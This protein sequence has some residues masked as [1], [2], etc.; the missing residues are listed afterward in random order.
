MKKR[1]LLLIVIVCLSY[2]LFANILQDA[3]QGARVINQKIEASGLEWEAG[4]NAG[5]LNPFIESIN[6]IDTFYEGLC[7]H[8]PL[9]EELKRYLPGQP[10]QRMNTT[11]DLFLSSFIL[12]EPET[13]EGKSFYR[14]EPVRNQAPYGS[15]WAFS[16]LAS[17]ESARAVQLLGKTENGNKDNALDYSERWVGYHNY[18][19]VGGTN[20]DQDR[21]NGGS[22][23]FAMYN[24]IRY[25]MIDESAAPYSQIVASMGEEKIPLPTSAYGAPRT[26]S[27]K[28][29]MI[30]KAG[31]SSFNA[32]EIG[33][34]YDEYIH[35]IKTAVQQYGSVSVSMTVPADFRSYKR[36]IYTPTVDD[37]L[38]GHAITLIGWADVDELD[39][40]TLSAKTNP[41]AKTVLDEE[42]S[43]YTYYDATTQTTKTT[44][45]CWILKNSWGYNWG[46]GGY[47]VMP[48]ISEEEYNALQTAEAKQSGESDAIGYWQIENS[49]MSVPLFDE[50]EKHAGDELD[51]NGDGTVS[52]EDFKALIDKIGETDVALGDLAYPKD[53]KITDDDV[54]AWIYL[55]NMR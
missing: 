53:R 8:E 33:Y 13:I 55:Y 39:T 7:G 3:E 50:Y 14:L 18:D 48:A 54:A 10:K 19:M 47:F 46:D 23:L 35:M 44:D 38:G 22:F 25:G 6:D 9:E 15:C 42:I 37:I 40:I 21:M 45:L 32:Q 28:T 5:F 43:T 34:S 49:M 27:S 4:P 17:F 52:E 41:D 31:G 12:L 11:F 51:I 1:E 16:T 26:H 24:G 30:P 20:Q 2:L 29:V 36:G